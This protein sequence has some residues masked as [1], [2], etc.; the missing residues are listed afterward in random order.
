[1]KVSLMCECEQENVS[2][3]SPCDSVLCDSAEW[4][5][6]AGRRTDWESQL[7]LSQAAAGEEWSWTEISSKHSELIKPEFISNVQ[8]ETGKHEEFWTLGGSVTAAA[9]QAQGAEDHG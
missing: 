6:S 2:S 9:L 7:Q 8:Q 3:S 4:V 5:P 1:M